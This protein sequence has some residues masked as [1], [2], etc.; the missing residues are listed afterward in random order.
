MNSMITLDR[1]YWWQRGFDA[2]ARHSSQIE[3]IREL[4]EQAIM[5]AQREHLQVAVSE[6]AKLA[7]RIESRKELLRGAP[8]MAVLSSQKNLG[9]ALLVGCL[10]FFAGDA[11][12]NHFA[13]EPYLMG[14]MTT[15]LVGFV[16]ALAGTAAAYY[17]LEC[18][19]ERK[20]IELAIALALFLLSVMVVSLFGLLRAIRIT[21][22]VPTDARPTVVISTPGV[23]PASVPQ[24]S[25]PQPSQPP[26]RNRFY[27][28]TSFI[29]KMAWMGLVIVMQVIAACLF[30]WG[31]R[32]V[33]DER[34]K[35]HQDQESD[36]RLR[37]DEAERILI[38]QGAGDVCLN[39]HRRGLLEGLDFKP[40]AEEWV[41]KSIKWIAVVGTLILI[42]MIFA[43]RM[44]GAEPGAKLQQPQ[45][46]QVVTILDETLST[47]PALFQQN[48]AA[49]GRVLAGLGPSSEVAVIAITGDSFGRPDFLLRAVVDSDKGF[50]G[51]KLDAAHEELLTAWQARAAN[52]KPEFKESDIFGA[53]MLASQVF[54]NCDAGQGRCVL[55]IFS[56]MRQYGRRGLDLETPAALDVPRLLRRAQ[57]MRLVP[58]LKR[59]D[60]RV[61]GAHSLGKSM[62]YWHQ[63]KAFWKSYFEI[64][65]ASLSQFVVSPELMQVQ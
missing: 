13:L 46:V 23:A 47:D 21:Q 48:L 54:R 62:E 40:P 51:E 28:D 64:A 4:D 26:R 5:L 42:Y 18:I 2:G 11:A 52:L 36:L 30:R 34:L 10:V 7:E 3:E 56:D 41:G 37:A 65:G 14:I 19:F 27:Q 22:P 1:G 33:T 44:Q 32:K 39:A 61:V 49:V 53:V 15:L 58:D 43:A 50:F 12:L 29:L 20:R 59:V 24:P 17:C 35:L 55:Y 6:E 57:A 9:Y 38:I 16:V 8:S 45:G 31:Y 60:V 63:M 25:Q